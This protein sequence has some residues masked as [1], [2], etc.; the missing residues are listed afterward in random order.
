M[1]P[2]QTPFEN[3]LPLVAQSRTPFEITD[4]TKVALTFPN[5]SDKCVT[6]TWTVKTLK[7]IPYFR[8]LFE[9][10]WRDSPTITPKGTITLSMEMRPSI[11]TKLMTYTLYKTKAEELEQAAD[12]LGVDLPKNH[13]YIARFQD[14]KEVK[15]EFF[16]RVKFSRD[17]P[18]P[19]PIDLGDVSTAKEISSVKWVPHF[20]KILKSQPHGLILE[21]DGKEIPPSPDV[22]SEKNDINI[23]LNTHLRVHGKIETLV[24]SLDTSN[25]PPDVSEPTFDIYIRYISGSF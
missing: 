15:D 14:A 20:R 6:Q 1:E 13:S 8:A 18:K 21:L 25:I 10:K 12:F 9:G 24:A 3:S 2:T 16:A 5:F 11:F 19:F 23:A 17:D 22:F 7:K 4:D